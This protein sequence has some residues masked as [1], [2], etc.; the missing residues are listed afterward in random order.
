M[1][2]GGTQF[3][4][5]KPLQLGN[6]CWNIMRFHTVSWCLW[7][8]LWV[9]WPLWMLICLYKLPP[10]ASNFLFQDFCS[11]KNRLRTRWRNFTGH[12]KDETSALCQ[13]STCTTCIFY[14]LLSKYCTTLF[15]QHLKDFIII[16]NFQWYISVNSPD[17]HLVCD[18]YLRTNWQFHYTIIVLHRIRYALNIVQ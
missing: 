11:W 16:D 15:F 2:W 1:S 13:V 5:E 9:K 18:R 7:K 8:S 17:I 4:V 10:F 14:P 12:L 3:H 6:P